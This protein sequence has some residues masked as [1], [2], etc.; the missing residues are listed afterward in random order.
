MLIFFPSGGQ[1]RGQ[2]T[3]NTYINYDEWK[4]DYKMIFSFKV[5]TEREAFTE[6]NCQLEIDF[7]A[8]DDERQVSF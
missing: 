8:S 2:Q 1:S 7:F 5:T 3:A 4:L 6:E